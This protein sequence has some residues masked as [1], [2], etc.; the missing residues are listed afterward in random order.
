MKTNELDVIL[1]SAIDS[2]KSL[3]G[4]DLE[5]V[6]LF[7]SYARRDFSQGESDLDIA[8]L[9]R[10][11][12]EE[13]MSKR[14]ALI[15]AT[16]DLDFEHDICISYRVIPLSQWQNHYGMLNLYKNIAEEGKV[17]YERV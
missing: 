12:P 8:V 16:V 13:V 4:N 6:I 10:C 17:Y 15:D 3:F 14:H 1:R 7:G 9:L 2:S 11:T 5:K